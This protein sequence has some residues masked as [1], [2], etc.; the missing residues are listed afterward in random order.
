M[1][2]LFLNPSGVLGGAGRSLIDI[3]ASLT[4][5]RPNWEMRLVAGSDGPLVR[6]ARTM[7][8]AVSVLPM[9]Q[10]LAQVGDWALSGNAG[11]PLA[12]LSM[13]ASLPGAAIAANRSLR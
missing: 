12:R 3:F 10:S 5:A 4:A 1:R 11:A 7:N 9:P 8:I 6:R 13:A 2:I